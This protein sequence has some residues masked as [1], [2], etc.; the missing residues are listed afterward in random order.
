MSSRFT[1][2]THC[3]RERSTVM[4]QPV[5]IVEDVKAREDYTLLIT[6]TGGA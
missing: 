6:F 3:A 5:W 4:N 1:G 2:L